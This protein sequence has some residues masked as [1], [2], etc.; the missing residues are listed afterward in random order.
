MK[1]FFM[2]ISELS[3]EFMQVQERFE[4]LKKGKTDGTFTEQGKTLKE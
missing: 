2:G 4:K 1:I 3:L